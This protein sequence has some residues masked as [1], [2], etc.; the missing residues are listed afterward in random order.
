MKIQHNEQDR[1]RKAQEQ[2]TNLEAQVTRL[3]TELEK[4]KQGIP[5]PAAAVPSAYKKMTNGN[6]NGN[7]HGVK[8]GPARPDSRASTVL[9]GESAS[10]SGTPN[11]RIPAQ[12]SSSR[13]TERS[14]TPPQGVW[15]SIHA[16]KSSAYTP[17]T[18]MS[19][20]YSNFDPATPKPR[21]A[22][23]AYRASMPS[24][25]P[26]SVSLAPTQGEDGWWS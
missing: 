10:R 1:E 15:A 18:S 22:A 19:M 17:P 2:I 11:L 20:R 3:R 26:S 23:Q 16:P 13:S 6:S 7:G 9:F 24:P 8:H 12:H 21:H 25:T 4:A 5:A 14:A